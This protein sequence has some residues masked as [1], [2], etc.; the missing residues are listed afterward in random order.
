MDST[1]IKLSVVIRPDMYKNNSGRCPEATYIK[2][3]E[4]A[5][6]GTKKAKYGFSGFIP[7]SAHNA[8]SL[9]SGGYY[10]TDPNLWGRGYKMGMI[11]GRCDAA[12]GRT[13][14]WTLGPTQGSN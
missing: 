7:S 12:P 3:I 14:K 11:E 10:T 1:C 2:N 6:R 4:K 9:Y 8:A 13:V 5:S